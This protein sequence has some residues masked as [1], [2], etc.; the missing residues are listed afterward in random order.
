MLNP[1]SEWVDLKG[2]I[3]L[4]MAVILLAVDL[5]FQGWEVT[6]V[7][8]MLILR[9]KIQNATKAQQNARAL[10]DQQK[11]DVRALK[12]QLLVVAHYL[13]GPYI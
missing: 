13:S 12:P 8:D 5:D 6:C 10:S 7:E 1:S 4:P 2:G 11:S 9:P 3:S